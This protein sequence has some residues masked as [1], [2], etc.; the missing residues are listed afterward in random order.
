MSW[1]IGM[2]IYTLR[3]IK[4]ITNENFEYN[5]RNSVFPGDLN[6]KEIQKREVICTHR[7]DS[8]CLTEGTKTTL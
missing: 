1:E 5:T 8:L 2:D 6:G 7:A 4:Q 3:C